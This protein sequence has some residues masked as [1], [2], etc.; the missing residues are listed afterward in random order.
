MKRAG[1]R[2]WRVNKPKS[3]LFQGELMTCKNCGRQQKSDPHV[4]SE[5]TAIELEGEFYGYFCPDCFG[6]ADMTHQPGEK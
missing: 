6:N 1:R 2:S 3:K 4:S 5:W